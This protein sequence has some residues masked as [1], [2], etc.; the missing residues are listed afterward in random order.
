MYRRYGCFAEG[1]VSVQMPGEKGMDD[2]Q[3]LMAQLRTTPPESLGGLKVARVRDYLHGQLL[4][5][6]R[7]QEPFLAAHRK[8]AWA[9]RAF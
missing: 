5:Q 1:Q 8:L 4:S 3:A 9:R 6:K 7:C 2:M